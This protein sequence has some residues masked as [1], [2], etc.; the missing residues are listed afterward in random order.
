MRGLETNKD[1][2][3]EEL[4]T[5]GNSDGSGLEGDDDMPVNFLANTGCFS[6]DEYL[7][8]KTKCMIMSEIAS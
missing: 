2:K 3:A 5:M 1:E 4:N 6:V 8:L 7:A